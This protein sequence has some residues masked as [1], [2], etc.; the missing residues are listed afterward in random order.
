[1]K[2][3]T[4]LVVAGVA[5]TASA[6][7]VPEPAALRAMNDELARSMAKLELPDVG[8]PYY[9][10]YELWDT[11]FAR[12]GASLG[13]LTYSDAGP[14]RSI[15]IDLR[16][17]SYDL[18]NSNFGSPFEDRSSV[19]LDLDDNYDAI[20]RDLWLAT[21][22]AY[23]AASEKLEQKQAILKQEEKD[24]DATTAF[25]KD[26]P[27]A[28]H[29]V[30]ALETPDKIRLEQLSRKLSGVFAKNR[31][32]YRGSVSC[33]EIVSNRYFVSSEGAHE[34]TPYREV[35]ITV[36]ASTQA[37]DG[38]AL[39]DSVE[40]VA[41][42]FDKLPSEKD[43]IARVEALSQ[44]LSAFRKAPVIEDY[45][46]PVLLRGVAAAQAVRE[47][48]AEDF[49]GTPAPKGSRAGMPATG[50]SALVGKVGQRIFPVGVSVVDDPT[51]TSVGALPVTGHYAFDEEGIAP[52]RVA[53][54]ENGVFKRFLMSRTPRKGFEHS[55]GH[56]RS[57]RVAP[58]R[59]HPTNLV[60]SSAKPLSEK[61]LVRRAL[62]AAKEQELPY[63]LVV[64]RL[65][66]FDA[67]DAT[68][69][70]LRNDA[71]MLSSPAVIKR[72]YPDG[73]EQ[74]VRGAHFATVPLQAL[75]D[76]LAIGTTPTAYNYVGSG[77]GRRFDMLYQGTDGI[78]ISI[79]AP[80]LLFRD[81]DLKAPHGAQRKPPIA[82]H[83]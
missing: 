59:A 54:V 46:G 6:D 69:S 20:R 61:E 50:E 70:L 35:R 62:A 5:V 14:R 80:S 40:I 13:S 22:G 3:I 76:L 64:D 9:L 1:M 82:P 18:D 53:V 7:P 43:M 57:T 19:T 65:A 60:L 49:A 34:S 71:G 29:E 41:P 73:R 78:A 15:D 44:E 52:Q 81:L 68:A 31:D 66:S 79:V 16:L 72:V 21:D 47:L 38:M 55:T 25:S 48:I 32:V 30:M 26:K 39:H 24:P 67:S 56:G 33:E 51:I 11:R 77:L 42:T 12:A 23:K 17:G 75:K 36:L 10:S 74:L 8:K 45:D 28:V 37:E 4:I 63:V 58:V 83:P 2:R 27:A